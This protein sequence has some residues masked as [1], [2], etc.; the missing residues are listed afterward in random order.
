M[1]LE[2]LDLPVK[3]VLPRVAAVLHKLQAMRGR[4]L[5]FRGG[6]TGD[7]THVG[8]STTDALKVDDDTTLSSFFGHGGL[9][10]F[11]WLE[12]IRPLA[13][14]D[15]ADPLRCQRYTLRAFPSLFS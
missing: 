8:L 6:V 5:V 1:S 2:L 4:A 12:G 13:S 7:T 3:F 15:M 9:R 11:V 14:T 10:R